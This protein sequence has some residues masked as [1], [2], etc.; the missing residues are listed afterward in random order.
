MILSGERLYVMIRLG[1]N[2]A[3]SKLVTGHLFLR[4]FTGEKT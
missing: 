3:K 1:Y 4:L 2:D